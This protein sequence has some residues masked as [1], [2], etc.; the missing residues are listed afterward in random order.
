MMNAESISVIMETAAEN[1]FSHALTSYIVIPQDDET[2]KIA[3]F[4]VAMFKG[5]PSFADIVSVY[6][7][8]SDNGVEDQLLENLYV[9]VD[10]IEGV[11][12]LLTSDFVADMTKAQSKLLIKTD[13]ETT[14][15]DLD[16]THNTV[17]NA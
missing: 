3:V 8:L 9:R 12:K 16:W 14:K 4:H 17:G 5:P 1:D 13:G 15:T 11:N 10:T 6:V 7:S 2:I